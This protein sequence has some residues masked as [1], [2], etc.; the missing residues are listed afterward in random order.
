M[1]EGCIQVTGV[2]AQKQFAICLLG[3]CKGVGSDGRPSDGD[4]DALFQH[5]A[6]FFLHQGSMLIGHHHGAWTTEWASS[7]STCDTCLGHIQ[8]P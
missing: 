8:F 5:L 3:I 6:K 7:H 2:Q 4:E 1:V